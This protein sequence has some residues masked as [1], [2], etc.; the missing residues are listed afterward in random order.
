[1]IPAILLTSVE[2]VAAARPLGGNRADPR[3]LLPELAPGDILSA[4][5]EAQLPDGSYKVSVA[6]QALSMKLPSY[7]APGDTLELAFVTREPRLT[8]VLRDVAAAAPQ[9]ATA[10]QLSAAGRLVAATMLQAGALAA[11]L[12]AAAAAPLLGASPADGAQLARALAKTLASSGLFYESHQAEW[13]AGGRDLAQIRQEPQA[14]LTRAALPASDPAQPLARPPQTAAGPAQP[15]VD[16]SALAS[17]AS[18]HPAAQSIDARTVALVQQQL[19]AL[20]SARVMLQ[21][22]I[23]PR[24]WMQWEIDEH[25][26]GSGRE[27]DAPPSWNTQLRLDLPR[28]GELKA[29]LSLSAAGVHIKLEAAS[30]TSAALMQ[31]QSTSLQSA[32]AAAGVPAAGIAVAHHGHA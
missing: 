14:Q 29:A 21:L 23:W 6:G 5:V 18:A 1:M 8:F 10:P 4:R 26:R 2:P 7:L 22:E 13:I 19:T 25:E 16:A 31:G 27:P 28:L 17:A 15:A 12:T 30:V 20:D 11:P 3:L 24:Q 9:P 32:L